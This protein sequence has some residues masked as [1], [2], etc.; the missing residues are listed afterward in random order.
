MLNYTIGV[1]AGVALL[2]AA[3]PVVASVRHPDQKPLAAYLIFITVLVVVTIV[4]FNILVWISAILKLG[5]DATTGEGFVILFVLALVP[6]LMLAIWQTRKPAMRR[7][8]PN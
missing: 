3:I 5:I 8:P 7:G 2:A 4:L 6:A 1:L